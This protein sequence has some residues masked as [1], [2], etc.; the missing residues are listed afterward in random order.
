MVVLWFG[1]FMGNTLPSAAAHKTTKPPNHKTTRPPNQSPRQ[2]INH[3]R[4]I[5]RQ[6][7]LIV[8]AGVGLGQYFAAQGAG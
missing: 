7:R 6:Q 3:R 4:F 2:P 8:F 1:G 5:Q